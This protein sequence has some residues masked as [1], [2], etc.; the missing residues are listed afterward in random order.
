MS[1]KVLK[2]TLVTAILLL[3]IVAFAACSSTA[4]DDVAQGPKTYT[5]EELATFDGQNGNPAYI[6]IEGVVY[7]VSLVPQWVGGAHSG[8]TAGKDLTENME[9]APH[10]FT[11][12]I[13][14]KEVGILAE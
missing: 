14:L 13:G 4:T 11:K 9:A 3:S 1:K 5:V 12:L 7:D 8:F 10:G 2:L 6:A